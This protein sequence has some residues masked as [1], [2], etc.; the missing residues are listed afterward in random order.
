LIAAFD[1]TMKD[2]DF[3]SDAEKLQA[4]ISPVSAR[5]IEALLAD[6]YATPKD[7]IAKAARAIVN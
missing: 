7:V 3:L 5:E 4:D 6:V 1:A 2:P